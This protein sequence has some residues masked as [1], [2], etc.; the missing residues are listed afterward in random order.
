MNLCGAYLS[1]L[2][3]AVLAV[4]GEQTSE[5]SRSTTVV[6]RE[7]EALAAESED[8]GS[9]EVTVENN[10]RHHSWA[11]TTAENAVSAA[12]LDWRLLKSHLTNLFK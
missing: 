9:D 3:A 6:S 2:V 11:Q 1:V 10:G 7:R 5:P 4:S 12:V 8:A